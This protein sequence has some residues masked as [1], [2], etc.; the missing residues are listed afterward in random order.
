MRSPHGAQGRPV[1]HRVKW[2]Q[3]TPGP[4]GWSQVRGCALLRGSQRLRQQTE[5]NSISVANFENNLASSTNEV[6]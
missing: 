5:S 4:L 1:G 2:A 3:T 6:N